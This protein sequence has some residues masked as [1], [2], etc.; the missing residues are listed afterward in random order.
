MNFEYGI[1]VEFEICSW[2]YMFSIQYTKQ[3]N[4]VLLEL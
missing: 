3:G 1:S 4:S 2:V